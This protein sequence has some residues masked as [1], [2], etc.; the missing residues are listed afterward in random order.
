MIMKE[1][2]ERIIKSG[3]SVTGMRSIRVNVTMRT[4]GTRCGMTSPLKLSGASHR[5]MAAKYNRYVQ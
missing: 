4:G 5:I 1:E 2:N 3:K